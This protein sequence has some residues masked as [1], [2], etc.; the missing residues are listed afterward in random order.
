M[1]LIADGFLSCTPAD[2]P[3]VVANAPISLQV[4]GRKNEEEAVLK[5]TE[6]VDAALKAS[7][8]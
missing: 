5:M 4:Y 3:E 8:R 6:I 1:P 7:K 2:R